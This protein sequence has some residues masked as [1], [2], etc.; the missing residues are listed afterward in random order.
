MSLRRWRL[1]EDVKDE[2]STLTKIQVDGGKPR[3]KGTSQRATR[4]NSV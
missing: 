4:S 2:M 3:G 1:S